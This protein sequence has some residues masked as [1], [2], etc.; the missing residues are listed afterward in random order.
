VIRKT[1]IVVLMLATVATAVMWVVSYTARSKVKEHYVLYWRGFC[2]EHRFRG[3]NVGCEFIEGRITILLTTFIRPTD[4][5]RDRCYAFHGFCFAIFADTF[6]PEGRRLIRSFY[7]PFWFPL[8][9]FA[10]YPVIAFIRGPLT[11]RY[12]RKHG[13]C[14]HCGYNLTGNTT[15]ICPECGKPPAP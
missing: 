2:V 8:F 12:R 9:L 10:A 14:P 11:R 3:G 1:I 4:H 15:G 5:V 7:M 6:E 13:L